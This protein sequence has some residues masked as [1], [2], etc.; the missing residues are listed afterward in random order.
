MSIE[1][2]IAFDFGAESGRAIL[3]SLET[4]K[5]RLKELHRFPNNK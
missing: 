3:G 2:F 1:R 4:K 5:I